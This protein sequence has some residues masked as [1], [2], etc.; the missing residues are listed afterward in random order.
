MYALIKS[1]YS[2]G[3]MH[4]PLQ[5]HNKHPCLGQNQS[6]S[7]LTGWLSFIT[8]WEY[9]H[10]VTCLER[11]KKYIVNILRLH[12]LTLLHLRVTHILWFISLVLINMTPV[13][14]A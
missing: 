1:P 14:T 8:G 4:T 11:I 12:T 3:K 5:L 9:S 13:L 6:Y 2:S 10:P 7:S